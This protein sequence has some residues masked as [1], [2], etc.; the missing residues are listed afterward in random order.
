[1]R[2]YRILIVDD[3]SIVRRGLRQL[4]EREVDFAVCGDTGDAAE[5][6][7]LVDRLQP[8]IVLTDLTLDGISGI[9]LARRLSSEHPSIP[10]LILSMHDEML[11]A[12]RALQAG[13]RGYVMKRRSEAEIVRA[14]REVLA[15]RTYVST[16]VRQSLPDLT[17]ESAD[18]I[19]CLTDREFEVFELLGQGYAP[20]HIAERLNL[21]VN[22]IEVYRERIKAKLGL[23][24]SSMLL[25]YA[26]QWWK[27]QGSG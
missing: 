18:I 13:A 3:H 19:D 11:Y 17:E 23:S 26:I 15:G 21:S 1:M 9:D 5:V 25:R 7:E 10:V 14:A 20:R 2:T 8:D 4:F 24:T 12:T 6:P 27:D 22:T 16:E